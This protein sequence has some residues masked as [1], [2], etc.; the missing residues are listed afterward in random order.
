LSEVDALLLLLS[1]ERG[2]NVIPSKTFEYMASGK[3]ILAIV[4][5][6]GEVAKIIRKS[7]TGLVADFEDIEGIKKAYYQLYRQWENKEVELHPIR[8]EVYK[9]EQRRLTKKFVSLLD[10]MIN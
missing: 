5:P 8:E 10:E 9:F 6:E 2:E 4:P 3:P 1:R 7:N